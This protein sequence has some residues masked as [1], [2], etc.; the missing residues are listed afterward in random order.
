MCRIATRLAQCFGAVNMGGGHPGATIQEDLDRVRDGNPM[1]LESVLRNLAN[2]PICLQIGDHDVAYKQRCRRVA[3]SGVDLDYIQQH[4]RQQ[5]FSDTGAGIYNHAVY[6]H[7]SEGGAHFDWEDSNFLWL[8]GELDK[9]EKLNKPVIADYKAWKDVSS[10][11]NDKPLDLTPATTSVMTNAVLYWFTENRSRNPLPQYLVWDLTTPWGDSFD[12]PVADGMSDSWRQNYWIDIGSRDIRDIK[13]LIEVAMDQK[14]NKIIVYS[15]GKYLRV[16]L[17]PGMP[18]S[19][20]KDI[21]VVVHEKG[22]T[23]TIGPIKLGWS[24]KVI[25]DTLARNDRELVFTSD[26]VLMQKSNGKWEWATN[27]PRQRERGA[28]KL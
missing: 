15:A 26:I 23:Q 5:V 7:T 18:V 9:A 12:D 19:L 6:V 20:G 10:W 13:T 28:A 11:A 21:Y 2:T 14:E 16:F 25:H 24:P 27:S 17:R 22:T 1:R 8:S 3:Q 4:Y